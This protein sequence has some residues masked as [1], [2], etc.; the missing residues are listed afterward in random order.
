MDELVSGRED[1]WTVG[2]LGKK[3][4]GRANWWAIGRFGKKE[5]GQADL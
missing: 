1:W 3:E 4:D 5:D 2:R